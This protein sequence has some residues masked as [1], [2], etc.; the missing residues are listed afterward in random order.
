MKYQEKFRFLNKLYFN[1]IFYLNFTKMEN[2]TFISLEFLKISLVSSYSL[3][4]WIYYTA[5]GKSN[6]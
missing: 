3:K 1:K 6:V 4:R 2:D 5:Q